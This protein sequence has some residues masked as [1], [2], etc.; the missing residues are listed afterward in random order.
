MDTATSQSRLDL[1]IRVS[2]SFVL[3]TV[4]YTIGVCIYRVTLHP[5]AKYPGPF[6][7][8][9]TDWSIVLQARSG[10]RHLDTWA[11]HQKYGPV[12]RIGPNVLSYNTT[13]ALKA[14][15][16][17]RRSNVRKSD[18]YK[19]IDAGSKA[20]SLHSEIDEKRHAFRRRVI[21]QAFSD[22]AIKS[23]E[24]LIV[25]DVTTWVDALGTEVDATTGWTKPKDMKDWCN[26]LSFDMMGDLTFG[27]GF[28]CVELGEHRFVPE[29]V[30][31]ATK[32][33]YVAGFWPFID[34][35]RPLLGTSWASMLFTKDAAQ[36]EAYIKY[37]NG[38]MEQ[39]MAEERQFDDTKASNPRRKDFIHH[40]LHARDPETGRGLS[41]NEL[42]ADSAL[43]IHAGSD[44]TALTLSGATFY[45]TDPR[46]E[47]VLTKLTT[48]IR[49][50]FDTPR[51][52]HSGPALG[53]LTYLRAVIDE[54]LRLA[55][56]VP[57][58]LPRQVLPGGMEIEGDY[59]PEGTVVGVAPFAIQYNEEYYPDPFRFKPERWISG[60]DEGVATAR[61]AFCPFSI[62]PR[63]CAGKRVAYLEVSI[64]LAT[65]LW[66]FDV[67]RAAA[68]AADEDGTITTT[69]D[70]NTSNNNNNDN[71][72]SRHGTVRG[73]R[74]LY[75]LWDHFV[76]DRKGPMVQFRKRV[77]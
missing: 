5:L 40:L 64:A 75:Q 59:V 70:N 31:D 53:S 18:W 71:K 22:T 10:D 56:P 76:A 62:G 67:K 72:N 77:D 57:S 11:E 55:P 24:D 63:G 36:G 39:R 12:V 4:V 27:K 58:H 23:D 15:Y 29:V 60:P 1:F 8:K 69:T 3:A 45:L 50:T 49:R 7:S 33:V 38:M 37:A 28:G 30:L 17:S 61:A 6:L 34:L 43:L 52:I 2:A 68:A 74:D 44:T 16:S 13:A 20:F 32:F 66:S 48:E 35:V 73:R 46:N 41:V 42:H 19:T 47:R 21:D 9:I 14:I 25:K 54:V 65:L 51:D 26:W